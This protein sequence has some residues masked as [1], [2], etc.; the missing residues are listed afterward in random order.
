MT[1]TPKTTVKEILSSKRL[2]VYHASAQRVLEIEESKGLHVGSLEQALERADF[3]VNDEELF[4][5]YY[6]HEVEII[7]PSVDKIHVCID[8]GERADLFEETLHKQR[9][10]LLMYR[11]VAEG[12]VK[13][14]NLSCVVLDKTYINSCKYLRLYK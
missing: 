1:L 6:I 7:V 12:D 5:E 8:K 10:N 2:K 11:N 4:T 14:N 3:Y 9:Y 13:E